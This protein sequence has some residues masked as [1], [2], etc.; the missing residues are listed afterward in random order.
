M[1][2]QR[3]KGQKKLFCFNLKRKAIWCKWQKE[4]EKK[5]RSK[6]KIS[7][8]FLEKKIAV[9]NDHSQRSW[10]KI[11][12]D[13]WKGFQ[14]WGYLG[15]SHLVA[16]KIHP[17]SEMSNKDFFSI[18]KKSRKYF[19]F[20]SACL[21]KNVYFLLIHF[22]FFSFRLFVLRRGLRRHRDMLW[23]WVYSVVRQFHE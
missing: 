7:F 16:F 3:R 20:L 15:I 1:I 18:P 19:P 11:K 10:E 2:L 8:T 23:R 17:Q 22:S 6:A 21:R 4:R 9:E 5:N 13:F 12:G 14:I